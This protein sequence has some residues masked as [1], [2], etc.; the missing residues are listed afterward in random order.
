MTLSPETHSEVKTLIKEKL[1]LLAPA[2]PTIEDGTP[3]P[4]KTKASDGVAQN[5]L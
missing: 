4:K 3:P 1:I 5:S 2:R